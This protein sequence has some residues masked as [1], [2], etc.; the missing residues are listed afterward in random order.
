MK[1]KQTN[2][3]R[4]NNTYHEISLALNRLPTCKQNLHQL[5]H[6]DHRE[7]LFCDPH[8]KIVLQIVNN[9]TKFKTV[10]VY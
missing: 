10:M 1:N 7:K 3:C 8:L 4:Q 5:R 2:R 9:V 6:P